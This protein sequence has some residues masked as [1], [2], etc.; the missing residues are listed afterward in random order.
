MDVSR[1]R[2]TVDKRLRFT[3]PK[4]PSA[5]SFIRILL[6]ERQHPKVH[7]LRGTINAFRNFVNPRQLWPLIIRSLLVTRRRCLNFPMSPF[8]P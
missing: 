4:L 1:L 5:T 3:T 2:T 7:T 8:I 6:G